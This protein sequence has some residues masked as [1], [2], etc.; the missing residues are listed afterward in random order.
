MGTAKDGMIHNRQTRG[1]I[2]I[3]V[4]EGQFTR[5]LE[6]SGLQKSQ[7][8][9]EK[10]SQYHVREKGSKSRGRGKGANDAA[11]T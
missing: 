9:I 4:Q 10:Y 6:G 1:C 8:I 11:V 2:H 7:G 5:G 3:E